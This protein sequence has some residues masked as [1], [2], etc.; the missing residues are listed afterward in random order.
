MLACTMGHTKRENILECNRY[1]TFGWHFSHHCD[2]E[3]MVWREVNRQRHQEHA[4][5][6]RVPQFKPKP[7]EHM[8]CE[9]MSICGLMKKCVY[10]F[11]S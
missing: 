5:S 1:S 3:V 4:P 7:V 6:G 10:F 11:S 8:K 2:I 9:V